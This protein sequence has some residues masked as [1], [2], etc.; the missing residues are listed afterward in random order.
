M[1]KSR[2]VVSRHRPWRPLLVTIAGLMLL[3]GAVYLA[4]AYGQVT[5]RVRSQAALLSASELESQRERLTEENRALRE[6]VAI[7][8]RAEQVNQKAYSDVDKYLVELQEEIFALKEEV[9]F[10]RGIVSSNGEQG[11]KIQSFKV[12]RDGEEGGFRFELVLTQDMKSGTLFAGTLDMSIAG[13]QGGRA[14]RLLS[15]EL[16]EGTGVGKEFQFKYFQMIEGRLTL[17]DGFAP[18]TVSV[19]I[20]SKEGAEV[21]IEKTFDWPLP[22]G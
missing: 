4:Y 13:E 5:L 6:R 11:L 10:Y 19:G 17:P 16:G 18:R 14:K 2:F 1:A 21:V 7:L 22:V 3:A 8:E 15:A 9:A 20:R 12:H